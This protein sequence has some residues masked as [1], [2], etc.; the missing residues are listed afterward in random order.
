M[1]PLSKEYIAF[2]LFAIIVLLFLSSCNVKKD[3]TRST[4]YAKTEVKTDVTTESVTTSTT[5]EKGSVTIETAK[6]SLNGQ[7]DNLFENPIYLENENLF[8]TVTEDKK[9]VTTAKAVKKSKKVNVPIDR[10]T[11]AKTIAKSTGSKKEN[12]TTKAK[13]SEKKVERTGGFNWNWLWLLL[14]IPI[15][16]YRKVLFGC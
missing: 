9:G 7:S 6:D 3:L 13:E 12:T 14:L 8:V 4:I 15:Y 10:V 2:Y 16:R 11:M 5:T 1:K